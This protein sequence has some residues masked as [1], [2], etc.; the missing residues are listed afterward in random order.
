ML[1][2]SLLLFLIAISASNIFAGK[3]HLQGITTQKELKNRIR[4]TT[5][6][7]SAPRPCYNV[8]LY[9]GTALITSYVFAALYI[10]EKNITDNK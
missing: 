8:G 9:T 5:P 3:K 7:S 6:P 1:K 2:Q 4:K 10:A